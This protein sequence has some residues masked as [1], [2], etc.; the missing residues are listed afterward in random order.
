MVVAN[1]SFKKIFGIFLQ[2]LQCTIVASQLSG[3]LY[4]CLAALLVE[5]HL[6]IL[7]GKASNVQKLCHNIMIF[8][9]GH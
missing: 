3:N 8:L 9:L 1:V 5:D 6:C 7:F 4:V 2:I